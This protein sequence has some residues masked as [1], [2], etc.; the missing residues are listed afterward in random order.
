MAAIEVQRDV[1]AAYTRLHGASHL[2]TL[3]SVSDLCASLLLVHKPSSEEAEALLRENITAH[4]ALKSPDHVD[5]TSDMVSL[6]IAIGRRADDMVVLDPHEKAKKIGLFEETIDILARADASRRQA[7]GPITQELP[8]VLPPSYA[9]VRNSPAASVRRRSLHSRSG[10]KVVRECSRVVAHLYPSRRTTVITHQ[11]PR[12]LPPSYTFVRNSPAA[13]V[14]WSR[15]RRNFVCD[16]LELSR[17]HR[18]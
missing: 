14:V 18:A 4:T 1:V 7:L 15:S 2:R 9:F 12:V 8:R 13:S 17:C 3:S 16:D 6:G 10:R 5:I 11:P